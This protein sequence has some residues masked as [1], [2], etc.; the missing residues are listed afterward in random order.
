MTI[1]GIIKTLICI[2]GVL[3][4]IHSIYLKERHGYSNRSNWRLIYGFGMVLS[5][6]MLK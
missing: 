5:S 1:I 2:Y 4:I 3:N 6:L